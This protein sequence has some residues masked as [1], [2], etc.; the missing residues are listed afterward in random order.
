MMVVPLV[1]AKEDSTKS[2]KGPAVDATGGEY[3]VSP[4]TDDPLIAANSAFS[5][6][7]TNYIVQ[8]Q[9]I[10]HSV[11]VGPG[12]KYL[13]VDLNWGDTTKSL[14]LGIYTPSASNIGTYRDN[15]DGSVNGRIHINIKPSNGYVQKGTWKFKVYGESVS[16]T[17][18]YTFNSAA[19]Y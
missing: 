13:E 15:S 2:G 10:Y 6:L 18:S 11:N 4:S 7:S 8:G 12:V 17:K 3:I 14:S 19:H 5:L 16:G 9:T 1:S